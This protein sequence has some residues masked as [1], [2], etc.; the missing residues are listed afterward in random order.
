[1]ASYR[2]GYL[3]AF[4]GTLTFSFTLPMVKIALVSFDP[5]AITFTRTT[6]AGATALA[7]VLVRRTPWPARD[8]WRTIALTGLGI[9]LGFPIFS[10][11]ALQRTTSAHGAVL[12]ASLPLV[13]AV[14]GVLGH[15]ERV[16]RVFWVGAGLGAIALGTYAWRHGGGSDGD[17]L[18]DALLIAAVLSSAFGYS[19]GARLTRVMPGWQV[20]SWCV[21]LWLPLSLAGLVAS[22]SRAGAVHDVQLPAALAVAFVSFG[23]MYLGFFAWYR[24]LGELGVA[25]GGQ[26]QMLQPLLTLAWSALLLRERI[27]GD[28]LATAAV[29]LACVALT[30]RARHSRRA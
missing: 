30:Q 17:P 23:S 21:I 19:E 26:I 25:R 5:W 7:V 22:Y 2:S 20:V 1:M 28:A 8:Q 29:V 15:G 13:T 3:F 9:S 24:G 6:V 12:I 10:T 14:F 16:S 11:L 27:G 4:L 18:A